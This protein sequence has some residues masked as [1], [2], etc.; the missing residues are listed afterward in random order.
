M[1]VAVPFG[2]K[3]RKEGAVILFFLLC[4]RFGRASDDTIFP[5]GFSF[6]AATA[7]YQIEGAWN[8]S[9][10][11]CIWDTY[12]FNNRSVIANQDT[13]EIACDSY[14]KYKE[15]IALAAALKL[16]HYRFSISWSRLLPTIVS[17][18]VNL[19]AL[20]Y[21][22]GIINE[23]EKYNI[24][25]MVTLYHWDLPQYLED[26]GGWTNPVIVDYFTDYA[27]VVFKYFPTVKLW[28]TINE[29]KQ[30]CVHGYG[31][32]KKAPG[33]TESGISDYRCAYHVAKAHASAYRLYKEKYGK[34]GGKLSMA[35]DGAWN[36]AAS[37]NKEDTDAAERR[38]LFEFGLYAHPIFFGDWP[39][40]VIERVKER[41]KMENFT[42]SRLPE[43][44]K[45]D[46]ILINNTV[47]FMALNYYD[48]KI[49][50]DDEEPSYDSYSYNN[51]LRLT[52]T[53]DKNWHTDRHLNSYVPEGFRNYLKW[54]KDTYNNPEIIITENGFADDGTVEDTDRVTFIKDY[55]MAVWN[56]I[57]KDKVKV[58]GYTFWSLLDNFEWNSGYDHHFGLYKV[59]FTSPNRTRT[60]KKS[61][62]FYREVIE[63]HGLSEAH[64]IHFMPILTVLSF[65]YL[66]L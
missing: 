40:V 2:I 58:T 16:S 35:L 11:A 23:L 6:G 39:E 50:G 33:L 55:L 21:Y 60:P 9:R 52:I 18:D 14:H 59:D 54:V 32:G 20:T 66:Y 25:P 28:I 19:E 7:A 5:E 31:Y 56:S 62:D 1:L 34:L 4:L 12:I 37:N 22:R 46:K 27:G 29:P 10:S 38:R 17:S 42:R 45:E 13:A 48:T 65:I 26:L 3:M 53:T 51:D 15:D 49:V 44:T 36:I 30:V 24:T 57:D 63:R 8:E 61:A 64:K 47:D 43:F 41:S